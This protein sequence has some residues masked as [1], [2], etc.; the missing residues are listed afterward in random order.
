M[1]AEVSCPLCTAQ[2]SALFYQGKK[3]PYL[4]C[5]EC[6]L[7]FV[8]P[9]CYLSSSAEKEQYQLHE[10]N[11]DDCRYRE[12]LSR[13][14][15]PL[16]LRLSPGSSGLDFGSGPGPTLSVMFEE[17]GHKMAIYDPFFSPDTAVLNKPYQFITATEVVEHLHSPGKVFSQLN[18]LLLPSGWLGVMTRL[19]PKKHEFA[20]WYYKNDPT[21]VC[22]YSR[23]T[24]RF[25]A[26]RLQWAVEFLPGGVTLFRKSGVDNSAIN[27]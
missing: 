8:P 10:N 2:E 4:Q 13:T 12:F 21:H 9:T 3:R 16:C 18:S 23:H 20:S 26:H 11:P 17:A 19:A 7:I 22:F 1:T 5:L 24:L 14:Y 6:Q 15:S 27:S 25:I